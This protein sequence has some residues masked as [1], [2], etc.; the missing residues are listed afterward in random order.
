MYTTIKS[1]VIDT[2]CSIQLQGLKLIYI[3]N[4]KL[5]SDARSFT[6]HTHVYFTLFTMRY[7]QL[8]NAG[9]DRILRKHVRALTT[10]G[11]ARKET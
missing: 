3:A 6:L 2:A 7:R 5:K 9:G 4:T 10:V 8:N 11:S 1:N